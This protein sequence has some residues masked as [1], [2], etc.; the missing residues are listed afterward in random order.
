MERPRLQPWLADA[1]RQCWALR[2]LGRQM[3]VFN[4][5][6]AELN[7]SPEAGIFRLFLV[8]QQTGEISPGATVQAGGNVM[9]PAGVV[10]L[11]KQ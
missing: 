9:L 6:E 7:L 1:A 8:N 4:R 5:R 3:L 2:E 11:V 10:W